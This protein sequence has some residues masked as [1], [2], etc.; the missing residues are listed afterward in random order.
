MMTLGWG[1]RVG[2]TGSLRWF[3]FLAAIGVW[4]VGV[5]GCREQA[6]SNFD[7]NIPPETFISG[8][9]AESTLSY[10]QVHL[11]WGGTDPD[12][13]VDHY[14]FSVTDSNQVPADIDPDFSGYYATTRTDSLFR[15]SADAPQI[16][17]HRFYVRAVDNEGKVDPT[18]AWTYFVSHDYNFPSVVW[19]RASGN[20]TDKYGV[21][22]TL[23]IKSNDRFDPTDTIGVGGSVTYAWSGFDADVGGGI[24]GF[25]WRWSAETD[26]RGGALADTAAS[27]VYNPAFSGKEVLYVRAI[28]DAGAKTLPDSTRSVV[29]NFNPVTWVL[30]QS[31]TTPVR[32]R[33]FLEQQHDRVYPTGTFLADVSGASARS[34]SFRYTGFD[35][36]RDYRPNPDDWGII[37]FQY[38]RL[39]YDGGPA[40]RDM[41]DWKKFPEISTFGYGDTQGLDSGDWLFL[42][43]CIDDLG[44]PGVADSVLVRVNYPP[45][46]VSV[47]Y[48]DK[49]GNPHPLWIPSASPGDTLTVNLDPN[50][51]NPDPLHIEF[52]AFD[53]H[54]AD[55]PNPLEL[56]PVVEDEDGQ[57]KEFRARV[58]GAPDG[59]EAVPR[60]VTKSER[61]LP[62]T[63]DP[64]AAGK[65][66]PGVNKLLLRV[67]DRG[68]NNGRETEIAVVFRVNM[69]E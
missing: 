28:D 2:F 50:G 9:P 55:N 47:N 41:N 61:F 64:A 29:V 25:Q 38:R 60:D 4:A 13:L 69:Q 10:Y 43:R 7:S 17:G 57:I 12:G 56:V 36:P 26:F 15:L 5:W 42:F 8:A 32:A 44:R 66:R 51:G 52:E 68:A 14:E 67:R 24:R 54:S 65:V 30:D 33:V 22:H 37:R 46:F 62:V 39:L 58:N 48:F 11:R 35:D 19:E 40:F 59:Y 31:S 20:W 49:L 63:T 34:V 45:Y 16:L 6:P 3:A 18:P 53:T 1:R 21:K 23:A 27:R